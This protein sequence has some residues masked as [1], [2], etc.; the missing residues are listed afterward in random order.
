MN[1]PIL[2]L[3]AAR[4]AETL[5]DFIHARNNRKLWVGFAL[6]ALL[7]AMFV[8]MGILDQDSPSAMFGMFFLLLAALFAYFSLS[9]RPLRMLQNKWSEVQLQET[10][11]FTYEHIAYT[12]SAQHVTHQASI[13]QYGYFVS[14]WE[15]PTFFTLN[16]AHGGISMFAKKDMTEHEQEV[17]R[18]LLHEKYGSR[19]TT[20]KHVPF[21]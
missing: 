9:K 19:F 21:R 7:S 4:D 13:L 16:P 8:V 11:S 5:T 1:D 18:N 14:A 3:H 10:F 12:G 17:F 20:R 6:F 15:F 2:T